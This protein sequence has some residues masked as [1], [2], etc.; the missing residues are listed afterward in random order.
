MAPHATHTTNQ[1]KISVSTKFHEEYSSAE[2]G[3]FLFSYHIKI[4]NESDYTLQLLSRHWDIFDSNNEFN[5]VDGEGVV[6]ETPTLEPGETYEYDSSCTLGTDI[7]FMKGHYLLEKKVDGS[8]FNVI[9]PQ[10]ELIAP[11]RL[12]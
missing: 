12:N 2:S 3:Q 9:I 11:Y 7:G 4:E 8:K 6:G 5:T 10:F 1:V